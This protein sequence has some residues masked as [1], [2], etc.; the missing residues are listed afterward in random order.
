[1]TRGQPGL[2][3]G[4][5]DRGLGRREAGGELGLH[6]HLAGTDGPGQDQAPQFGEHPLTARGPGCTRR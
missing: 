2:A 4:L 5:A 6:E 1:M 3:Q